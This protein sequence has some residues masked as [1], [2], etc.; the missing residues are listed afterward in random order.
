MFD[1]SKVFRFTV[2]GSQNLSVETSIIHTLIVVG[3][4]EANSRITSS[5]AV[6]ASSFSSQ[7]YVYKDEIRISEY[8][9]P[10][11]RRHTTSCFRVRQ[12]TD[13]SH[14]GNSNSQGTPDLS[15]PKRFRCLNG[16]HIVRCKE[17]GLK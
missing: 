3:V 5:K 6:I 14:K 2:T 7:R 15:T 16:E 11:P 1:T 9:H 17:R 10:G 4:Y 12:P 8:E 13:R